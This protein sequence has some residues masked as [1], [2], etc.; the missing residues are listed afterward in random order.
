MAVP[1]NVCPHLYR[2]AGNSLDRKPAG[3]DERI[4]VFDVDAATGKVADRRD[5]SRS[6]SRLDRA[7]PSRQPTRTAGGQLVEPTGPRF[8]SEFP[9][10]RLQGGGTRGVFARQV[11]GRPIVVG[12]CYLF[13]PHR[14]DR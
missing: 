14:P 1:E 6:L 10:A 5:T 3:I 8:G 12:K 13:M 2:L 11:A 9:D 7:L 4:D